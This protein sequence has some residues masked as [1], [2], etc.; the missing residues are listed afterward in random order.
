[1]GLLIISCSPKYELRT[2]YKLPETEKGKEC[3]NQCQTQFEFCKNECDKNYQTCL[4]IA[5]KRAKEIYKQAQ[6]DYE[7]RFKRYYREYSKYTDAYRS[8]LQKYERTKSDYEYYSRKCA[9]DKEW[10]DE[11]NFYRRML[12]E[13]Y[14][15]KPKEPFKPAEPSFE[16]ILKA[17]QEL[18][19]KDCGCRDEYNLCFQQCG[20]KI[21]FKKICVE[22]CD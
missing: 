19:D 14:S 18:C 5:V 15:Q 2:V 7:I 13:L 20:G 21:E 4:N 12:N 16:K 9:V 17:Q 8:W 22:H 1:L 6:K 3:V 11:K 10:C